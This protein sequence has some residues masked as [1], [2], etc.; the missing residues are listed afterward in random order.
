MDLIVLEVIYETNS[1][2]I[3]KLL[4][5]GL[6]GLVLHDAVEPDL[7]EG[8]HRGPLADYSPRDGEPLARGPWRKQHLRDA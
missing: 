8:L 3:K 4:L 5:K 7:N 2:G 1:G 6:R